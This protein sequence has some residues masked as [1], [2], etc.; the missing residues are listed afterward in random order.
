[1]KTRS[2]YNPQGLRLPQL[3][4]TALFGDSNLVSYYKLDGNSN[5]NKGSNNGTDTSIDYGVTYGKFGQGALINANSD[6]ISLGDPASLKFSGAHTI[7]T[8]V[9]LLNTNRAAVDQIVF[10]GNDGVDF[11][12][13]FL[14]F[15]GTNTLRYGMLANRAVNSAVTCDYTFTLDSNWHLVTATYTGA[16]MFLYWDGV[17][18]GTTHT[19]ISIDTTGNWYLGNTNGSRAVTKHLDDV[20]F[21]SRALTASEIQQLYFAGSTKAYYPLNGNSNDYSGNGNHGTDTAITYPQGKFGQAAKFDGSSS[22]ISLGAGS[23]FNNATFTYSAWVNLQTAP[24]DNPNIISGSGTN[25]PCFRINTSYQLN[26]LGQ[27]VA[28]LVSSSRTIKLN[29]WHHV[30]VTDDS[31]GNY[32]FYIDGYTAGSGSHAAQTWVRTSNYL[33]NP[34]GERWNG[35]IDE[36][37]IESRA[38]TAKEVETY[39]RKS[40]LNYTPAKSIWNV[41]YTYILEAGTGA[42]NTTG[43][44]ANLLRGYKLLADVANVA[45]NG[46]AA[47]FTRGYGMIV[48]VANIVAR[49]V[50]ASLRFAG[51]TSQGKNSST[52]SNNSKNTSSYSN[53]SKNSSTWSNEDK[54]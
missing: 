25:Y 31:S 2:A 44:S 5:D 30:V 34:S 50:E 1:M 18:V 9:N 12:C 37:I 42:I 29:R 26:L 33:G 24:T 16:D 7:T 35:L 11:G 43:Q 28:D 52:W 6:R 3:A 54:S 27:G 41:I 53:Q 8:W 46:V 39:Y 40:V 38:W 48:G 15:T 47:T 49:G 21:F 10:K 19:S 32:A 13:L 51:W 14:S 20:A 45:V 22:S 17:Q 36:V 23:S 4:D